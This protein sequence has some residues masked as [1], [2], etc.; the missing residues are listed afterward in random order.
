MG[1]CMRVWMDILNTIY[2]N[3]TNQYTS[4]AV[5][6][7]AVIEDSQQEKHYVQNIEF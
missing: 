2:E 7:Q 6:K 5:K 1:V 4:L 3:D